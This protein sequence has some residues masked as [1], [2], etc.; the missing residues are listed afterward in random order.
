MSSDDRA[1]NPAGKPLNDE[2]PRAR[3]CAVCTVFFILPWH[4]VVAA[5]YASLVNAAETY[6]IFAPSISSALY[7][8]YSWALLTVLI[9]SVFTGWNRKFCNE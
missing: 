6:N 3:D 8:P 1:G 5:W 2:S 9:F 7:N 4:I